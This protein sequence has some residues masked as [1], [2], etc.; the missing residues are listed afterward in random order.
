[1]V[2][3]NDCPVIAAT[4]SARTAELIYR[5]LL[6]KL[7]FDEDIE[8][9][10]E[11][12]MRS[13]DLTIGTPDGASNPTSPGTPNG[14]NNVIA[15]HET[16]AV[17]STSQLDAPNSIQPLN[18]TGTATNSISGNGPSLGTNTPT[19]GVTD[20]TPTVNA[21]DTTPTVNPAEAFPSV[22]P[23]EPVAGSL[24]Y[25]IRKAYTD[26]KGLEFQC[27]LEHIRQRI[28]RRNNPNQN[29][30]FKDPNVEVLELRLDQYVAIAATEL[31]LKLADQT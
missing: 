10:I 30:R 5:H 1:M 20:T 28:Q 19:V 29:T 8:D 24:G 12:I 25:A 16:L 27:Y 2:G 15:T 7:A 6:S 18:A 26:L 3:I 31:E 17:P 11:Q 14:D 22:L 9:S 13:T 23:H 21:T 4:Y